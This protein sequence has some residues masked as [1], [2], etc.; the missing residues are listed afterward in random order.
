LEVTIT[1][2]SE[3]E[4][5]AS[6]ALSNDELQPHFVEAYERFRPKAEVRGFRKGK[7]PLDLIR[8]MYGEAIEHDALDGIA[9]ETFRRTMEEHKVRPL[10]QPAM[11]DMDFKRGSHFKF[12]IKYEIRPDITLKP[13]SGITIDRPVHVVAD[14]ELQT[15]LLQIQR[16][17]AEKKPADRVTNT[18]AVVTADVQEVDETGTPLIGKKSSNMTF[19]LYDESLSEEIRQ[20]LAGAE[21][22]GTY[23]ASLQRQDGE[24]TRTM[25]IAMNVTDIQQLEIPAI[26]EAL[27]T[28]VTGGRV[29]NPDEFKESVRKDIARFWAEQ[30]ESHVRNAL[31]DEVVRMHEFPVPES[32][33]E[34]FLDS[35]I[36]DIKSRSKGKSLPPRFDE[37]AFRQEQRA[38]AIW[39]A[40]WMLIKEQIAEREKLDVNDAEIEQA[41]EADAGRI[42]LAKDKLLAYYKS[43]GS[44]RER[45]ISDKIMALLRERATITDRPVE[46]HAP[47]V[48]SV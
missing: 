43:S 38:N 6:I 44:V 13:T 30:S 18:E 7:V 23:R 28:K 21:R 32:L 39:Q 1:P 41:A 45:I 46:A 25:H 4:Q 27:A 34:K 48:H 16:S 31:A 19:Q 37:K 9:D 40:R 2:L 3:V 47:H 22:G 35:F 12:T 29:T 11:V 33:I 15:E 8:K 26:D 14:E 36:E 42:G 5:Q 24:Q 17:N 20:A 10:G